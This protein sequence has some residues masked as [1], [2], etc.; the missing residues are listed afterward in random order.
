[1]TT[2]SEIL[3]KALDEISLGADVLGLTGYLTRDAVLLIKDII[4]RAHAGAEPYTLEGALASRIRVLAALEAQG[5]RVATR[6]GKDS[7]DMKEGKTSIV[8]FNEAQG[9]LPEGTV[10]ASSAS[11]LAAAP[12]GGGSAFRASATGVNPAAPVTASTPANY[13]PAPDDNP[14]LEFV[15]MSKLKLAPQF[16]PTTS[17]KPE[18]ETGEKKMTPEEIRQEFQRKIHLAAAGAGKSDQGETK[19]TPKSKPELRAKGRSMPVPKA[20]L[21]V[22]REPT[23]E[24]ETPKPSFPVRDPVPTPS[25]T[26][27]QPARARAIS[28]DLIDL[29]NFD[30]AEFGL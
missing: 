4:G 8:G 5:E 18:H 29:T 24:K 16:I 3:N 21:K 11:T 25:P 20:E 10:A 17:A 27:P 28:D 9:S 6:G 15:P 22:K 14:F 2:N 30:P 1:M 12:P 26:P 19:A 13:E 7:G 23:L